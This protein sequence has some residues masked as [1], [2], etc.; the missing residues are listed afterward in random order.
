LLLLE[1]AGIELVVLLDFDERVRRITAETFAR[2]V[3][4][5]DL[6]VREL[7]L[8]FDS[9][10]GRD[11]EGTP[12][13]FA[14]LGR[15]H[16]FTV[17][18]IEPL[19]MDNAP[20]SS[21]A[22]RSAVE[23][24]DL[25]EAQRMLGRPVS[26]LGKVVGGSQRGRLLGFPTAN[27]DLMGEIRPPVGVYAVRI[28]HLDTAEVYLGVCNIG[29]RPTFAHGDLPEQRKELLEVHLLEFSGDLYGKELEVQFV[30]RLRSEKRFESG[31]ALALQIEKDVAEARR[32]LGGGE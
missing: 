10:L 14:E 7:V 9:A 1:R 31:E 6:G 8:G 16:G 21:T 30:V 32:I 27:L 28:G 3:L 15:Q 20:V 18:V 2:E 12:T 17:T 24:G 26:V 22:I 13:R 5:R 23:G 29:L 19:R 11:R 25:V 4:Q